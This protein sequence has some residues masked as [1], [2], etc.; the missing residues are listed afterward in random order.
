MPRVEV[1]FAELGIRRG[2]DAPSPLV[3]LGEMW[4]LV[5]VNEI[6]GIAT[7]GRD[8]LFELAPVPELTS[9]VDVDAEVDTD[10]PTDVPTAPD[11]E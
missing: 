10:N 9:D 4:D 1:S 7:Y 8:A 11:L 5:V 2:S 6:D 3:H